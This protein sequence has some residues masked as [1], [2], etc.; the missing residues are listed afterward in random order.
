MC[1]LTP[2]LLSL[3]SLADELIGSVRDGEDS[4][5]GFGYGEHGVSGWDDDV[6]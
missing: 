3:D 4:I 6:L 5:V 1:H 2:S